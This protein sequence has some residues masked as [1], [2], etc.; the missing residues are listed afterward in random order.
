MKKFNLENM[1]GGWIIGNFEPSLLKTNEVEVAIKKYK[2]GD[3]DS[4]HY[5][6]IAT[7]Y[8]VIVSGQ[9]EMS[10]VIYNE[11]DILVINPSDVTDFRAITDAITVV[12]KIPGASNDKYVE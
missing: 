12:V 1:I 2:A 3:Y 6:K 10:G 9:V 11:N 4:A 8:T 7:E 5:H